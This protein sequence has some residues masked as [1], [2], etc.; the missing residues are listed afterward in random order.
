MLLYTNLRK[1][2]VPSI[3]K[4]RQTPGEQQRRNG[5]G[6]TP[7]ASAAIARSLGELYD[8]ALEG[9]RDKT[10]DT[11]ERLKYGRLAAYIAQTINSV[12]KTYDEVRIETTLEEL[13]EYVKKHIA[14]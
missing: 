8:E 5:T 3:Q 12:T 14:P 2:T 13:K 1:N 10:L 9:S 11:Y 4:T 7:S 6:S